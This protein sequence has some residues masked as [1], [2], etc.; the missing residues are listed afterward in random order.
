MS[1]VGI[2]NSGQFQSHQQWVGNEINT[3]GGN[4]YFGGPATGPT[5]DRYDILSQSLLFSRIDDRVHSI[6]KALPDTCTW[7]FQHDSFNKWR[8]SD[9]L[10]RHN[11]FL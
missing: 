11:G 1:P 8:S 3:G 2:S 10:S 5:V 6:K 9:G 7:L 4:V